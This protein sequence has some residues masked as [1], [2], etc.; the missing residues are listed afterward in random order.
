MYA[1]A[2]SQFIS[3]GG[4]E[5]NG[6][7]NGAFIPTLNS[8]GVPIQPTWML[9]KNM[10]TTGSWGIFDTSRSPT[11]QGNKNIYPNLTNAEDT[12]NAFDFVTGGFKQRSGS[13]FTNVANTF[14]YMAIGTPIIDVDG[15]II[16]GR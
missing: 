15:R 4:Y 1:F 9:I 3:I 12:G 13:A 2:P 8:L 7:G 5:G 14:V 10:D 16:A 6:N 11:N